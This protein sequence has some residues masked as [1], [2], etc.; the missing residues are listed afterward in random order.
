MQDDQGT[1]MTQIVLNAGDFGASAS[2]NT[3]IMR[4]HRQGV[5]TSASLMVTPDAAAT[6]RPSSQEI[7]C[8]ARTMQ[9]Q[10]EANNG[11]SGNHL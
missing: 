10:T 1:A 11:S 8:A 3:A 4:A 5:L 9:V 7:P 6:K 2:I